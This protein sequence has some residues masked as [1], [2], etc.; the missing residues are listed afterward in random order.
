GGGSALPVRGGTARAGE[1]HLAVHPIGRLFARVV[2]R[3]GAGVDE[4]VVESDVYDLSTGARVDDDLAGAFQDL[5][6]GRVGPAEEAVAAA[7]KPAAGRGAGDL[8][9]LP[10]HPPPWCSGRSGSSSQRGGGGGRS[11]CSGP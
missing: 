1:R 5:E 9:R 7:G 6:A 8:V 3:A 11:A 10:S 4:A 2:L